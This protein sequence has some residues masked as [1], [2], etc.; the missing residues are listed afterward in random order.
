MV[1]EN[2]AFKPVG[3]VIRDP[4]DESN[5]DNGQTYGTD[6]F[7]SVPIGKQPNARN[8]GLRDG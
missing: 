8:P 2:T 4:P 3:Q 7:G 1:R 6:K 5:E